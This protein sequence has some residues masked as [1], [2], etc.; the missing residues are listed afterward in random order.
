LKHTRS[1]IVP[2]AFHITVLS[3]VKTASKLLAHDTICLGD[4]GSDSP[5]ILS[6]Y[7]HLVIAAAPVKTALGAKSRQAHFSTLLL[8][9]C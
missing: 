5:G 3:A 7:R 2:K 1:C 9:L 8:D 4:C 6:T